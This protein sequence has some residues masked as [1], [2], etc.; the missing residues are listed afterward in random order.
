MA[1]DSGNGHRDG[2]E[3]VRERVV[4]IGAGFAGLAAAGALDGAGLQV[5]LVDQHDYNTFQPLLY[6]VATAGLN[7]GDIAYPLRTLLRHYGSTRFRRG[8][9]E[10]IDFA[11]RK[12][13][14]DDGGALEYEYLV[15]ATGA[16]TSY[17]GVPGAEEHCHAIYTLDDALGVR[18]KI[19][20]QM[21][22][23]SAL[24]PT[25]AGMTIAVIGGGATGVEMAG[26]LSE[27]LTLA[28]ATT[29]RELDPSLARVVLV[30]QRDRLL[31]GFDERLARYA[32]RQL[33]RRGVEVRLGVEVLEVKPEHLVLSSPADGKSELPCGLVVW[34][35]GV[36]AGKLASSLDL[37]LTRGGR[38]VVDEM[39]H[40]PEHPEVFVVGDVAGALAVRAGGDGAA[41]AGGAGQSPDAG[42]KLLPQLAQ[43][44]IQAGGHAGLQIL[45]LRAGQPLQPFV[46][47]DKGTMATIG[48]RAAIAEV[49]LWR[50]RSGAAAPQVRLRGT[51]AWLAWLGLHIVTLL[52]RRNR[53][54]VLLN[55][56]WRY[57]S[58]RGGPRVIIGG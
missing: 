37:P 23:A 3:A 38:I 53:A 56:S 33:K 54:S 34:A 16:T 40:V 8:K 43:P 25:P 13:Q 46:Y 17:F 27:L 44:A 14:F 6:Q 18:A 42:A 48:R 24:G 47:R 7:P 52:G 35:A 5:I 4:V 55:W 1:G 2:A 50:P 51:L 58:W 31:G 15:L 36:A 41:G 12:V 49:P 10:A 11:S 32:L 20:A 57:V 39:L 26:A 45:R 28:L 30:E 22:R 21:E 29:Y 19:F 9:V